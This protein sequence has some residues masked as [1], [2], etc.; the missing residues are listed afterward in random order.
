LKK[1]SKTKKTE[2]DKK[3]LDNN[4]SDVEI[5]KINMI[6]KQLN[7]N[8]TTIDNEKRNIVKKIIE[9]YNLKYEESDKE[10]DEICSYLMKTNKVYA[11]LSDDTDMFVYGCSKILRNINLDN[12]SVIIY[13]TKQIFMSFFRHLPRASINRHLE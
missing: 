9:S 5:N 2:L 10:A 11:C 4:L 1:I 6:I 3:L 7:Q 8:M 13:D 12:E